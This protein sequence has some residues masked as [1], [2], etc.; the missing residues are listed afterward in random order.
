[1]CQERGFECGRKEKV[2]GPQTQLQ[3]SGREMERASGQLVFAIP[4]ISASILSDEPNSVEI[5]LYSMLKIENIP[6]PSDS[7]QNIFI[8]LTKSYMQSYHIDSV[9][10]PWPDFRLS[11]KVFRYA[12]LTLSSTITS[13]TTYD[14]NGADSNYLA[15]FY[16]YM[17]EAIEAKSILEVFVASYV[18]VMDSWFQAK[19][20]QTIFTFCKGMSTAYSLLMDGVSATAT[21]TVS[22]ARRLMRGL[23]CMVFETYFLQPPLETTEVTIYQELD[24]H[25][26]AW[27][28]STWHDIIGLNYYLR[29]YIDCYLFERRTRVPFIQT[30][31]IRP[32]ILAT[33]SEIFRR[34][35]PVVGVSNKIIS[36]TLDASLP[37]PWLNDTLVMDDVLY[38]LLVPDH[39]AKDS[40]PRALWRTLEYG[41]ALVIAEAV[42]GAL[43]PPSCFPEFNVSPSLM[44]CRLCALASAYYTLRLSDLPRYFWLP[45]FLWA[46]LGLVDGLEPAGIAIQMIVLTKFQPVDGFVACSIIISFGCVTLFCYPRISGFSI[47]SRITYIV[48]TLRGDRRELCCWS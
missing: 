19:D 12:A 28:P 27:A 31:S 6:G 46:G 39:L 21:Y 7:G 5:R 38:E 26:R 25:I 16:E 33:L 24:T 3:P 10:V 22:N 8:P 4:R 32:R 13:S 40:Y 17:R 2:F 41:F 23:D 9:A 47:R 44:L 48:R 42:G 29:L 18:M 15:K 20:L 43:L 36:A 37:W 45:Y 1:M 11:S 34:F 35:S 30:S 14:S